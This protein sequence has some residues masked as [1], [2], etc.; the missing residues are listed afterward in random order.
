MLKDH[1]VAV[2]D[3][4]LSISK[5]PSNAGHTLHKGTPREAFIREFL[6]S[7]LSERVAIGTGE[8]IDAHSK[9]GESRNQFDIVIYKRDYPKLNFG[10]G[11]SGFLAESVIATIEVKSLL[12]KDAIRQSIEAARNAKKL[13][14]NLVT[15]FLTGYIPPSIL[16]YVVADNGPMNID[17]VYNWI[18]EIYGEKGIISPTLSSDVN[19][20]IATPSSS[21]DAV[22]L[23]GKGFIYFDNVPS[24]FSNENVWLK[25]PD[26]HWAVGKS[27]NTNLL[28][29]FLFLTQA[30][31]GIQAA[32]LDP[33]PYLS[34]FQVD[35][36]YVP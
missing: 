15:S 11:I 36:N 9:S 19:I 25:Y 2:E 7:H 32:W 31:S 24:G 3:Y 23:L 12:D 30:A 8:I 26:I 21:I 33:I 4:L 14:R 13:Q 29:L 35:V 22:F 18:P 28:L 5:I 10:G 34:S 20:R 6:Q 16:N 27:A 17:T 1:F